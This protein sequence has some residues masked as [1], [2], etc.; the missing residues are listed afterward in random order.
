METTTVA[1]DLAKDVFQVALANRAGRI[2][3]S[4]ASHTTAIRALPRA[5]TDDIQVIME[6]CGTSHYWGR[7]L[8]S[9]DVHVRLLP[10]Q[11]GHPY[12]RRNGT[13]RADTDALLEVARCGDI[14]PRKDGRAADAASDP[15]DP[16]PMADRACGRDQCDAAGSPF[17][18]AHLGS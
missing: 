14:R 2:N 6:S 7:R 5:L 9:R 12:L 17:L 4:A 8:Q 1:I 16:H 3:R 11:Y 10:V 15:P 13:D 18:L